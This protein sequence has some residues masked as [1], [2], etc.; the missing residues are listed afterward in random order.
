MQCSYIRLY[1]YLIP[2]LTFLYYL[3]MRTNSDY[4]TTCACMSRGY[5]IVLVSV[6]VHMFRTFCG[7]CAICGLHLRSK[8]CVVQFM[9]FCPCPNTSLH[10]LDSISIS[11]S[12]SNPRHSPITSLCWKHYKINRAKTR[13]RAR[14]LSGL[15]MATVMLL[16]PRMTLLTNNFVRP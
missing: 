14:L 4:D 16:G 2:K 5:M 3:T 1:R 7:F 13:A 9:N 10:L 11:S 15:Q 8:H 6:C 12:S